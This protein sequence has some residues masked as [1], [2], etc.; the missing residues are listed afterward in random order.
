MKVY[1]VGGAVRD[2]LLGLPVKERDWVVVGSSPEQLLK[3]NFRQ[4][5]RDFPV[6]LH[7]Q[8]K[9]EY[10]L[11]RTER[12]SA[13][14]YYGFEC[15]FSAAVTLEED[16]AR[17]DLTINA[18]AMDE[19]GRIIDPYQGQQ[20]IH[21]KILRH[22]SPAFI[23][24]P[25]RVLRVARFASRFYSLGFTLANETRALMY[26]MVKRG[27]LSHLVPERVWQEFQRSLAEP[28]PEQFIM[29]LRSCGALDVILPEINSLFGVPNTAHYHPE[30]DS[31]I[32]SL[33][34]LQSAVALSVDP[35]VR[36][37]A[38]VH[39]LGKGVTPI[40][41]WPKHH[42]HEE[43][44]VPVIDGLCRRLRIPN[45][46]RVLAVLVARYHLTI[47]RLFELRPNTIV[48]VLERTDAFRKPDLFHQLLLACQAD[49]QGRGI[50]VEYQQ[51]QIW[52]KI[53]SECVK[54]NPKE[55]IAQGYEGKAI[56]EALH[57]RRIACV[58]QLLNSWNLNEK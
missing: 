41:Q 48:N 14:G 3:Q 56:K 38:L 1:L 19:E 24:D 25:V 11:A 49:S 52:S 13:P 45:D 53:L 43:T 23:E 28:N 44:G 22:V 39:D 5:G 27:E 8:T 10:A 34:V 4:V 31:G 33:M 58:K 47:H 51:A 40:S 55:L 18:M 21:N 50:P 2:Q 6:F 7:P 16:L 42:Q 54:V 20:D 35:V 29:T 12:K 57:E 15:D 17:R 9:E 30:I 32:H 46:Y 36:F 26:A 37:A